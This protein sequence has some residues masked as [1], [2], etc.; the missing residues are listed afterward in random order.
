MSMKVVFLK[1]YNDYLQAIE[2]KP[3]DEV[4]IPRQLGRRLCQQGVTIP[5][6]IKNDHA[7][8]LKLLQAKKEPESEPKAE[9]KVE[10][11][12]KKKTGRKKAIS[13][14]ASTRSKAVIK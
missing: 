12:P 4:Y 7:E 13:R 9:V 6:S 5:W 11:K 10:K 14:K 3:L 8:Y 2:Y 1:G